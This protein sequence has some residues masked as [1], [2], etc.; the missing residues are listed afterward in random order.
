M[1]TSTTSP[2]VSEWVTLTESEWL[3]HSAVTVTVT[4]SESVT[5]STR[6]WL[7]QSLLIVPVSV[8]VVN[9][10]RQPVQTHSLFLVLLKTG[11]KVSTRIRMT[12]VKSFLNQTTL[13]IVMIE[14]PNA[15]DVSII[16]WGLLNS[17]WKSDH[18]AII[19]A[20]DMEFMQY[21]ALRC[22]HSCI[23]ENSA[24]ITGLQKEINI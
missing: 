15:L 10:C 3:T 20:P 11:W 14:N 22:C 1:H 23:N 8:N 24:C 13:S 5:R 6:G 16:R 7:S 17:I 2:P 18:I 21:S 4:L 12:P 19:A 9:H